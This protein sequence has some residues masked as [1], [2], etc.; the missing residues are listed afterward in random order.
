[1]L[2]NRITGKYPIILGPVMIRHKKTYQKYHT[3]AS[4][5]LAANPKLKDIKAI[6]TDGEELLQKSFND[7]FVRAQPLQDL[8]HFRQN[9]DSALKDVDISAKKD[10]DPFLNDAFG[11]TEGDVYVKGLC[12]VKDDHKRSQLAC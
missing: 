12:D 9:M 7:V 4:R 6:N 3:L 2:N 5:I 1:M 11:H 10:S 8:R